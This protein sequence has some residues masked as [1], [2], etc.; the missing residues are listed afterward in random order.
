MPPVPTVEKRVKDC[1][2][3]TPAAPKIRNSRATPYRVAV[4]VGLHL[5]LAAHIAHYWLSGK[6][7]SPLEPSEAMEFSKHSIVNAGLVFFAVTILATLVFGRF[8]CGWGCHIVALQDLCR[9]MLLRV[10]IRPRPLRSRALALVPLGAFLYMFIWPLAYRVW[11]TFFG[12]AFGSASVQLQTNDFWRT[13]PGLGVT[14]FTFAVCG[15]AIVYL[16]GSKG[17]CTYACPYG[18]IFGF[19][20][21]FAPGR[22]RVTDACEGCG[23]CTATCT[24]NV[25]VAREVREFGMV[26]DAGCMKCLDCVSVCPKDAL[27]FGFGKPGVMARP[28]VERLS[29]RRFLPG[30]EEILGGLIFLVAFFTFRGLYGLVPFLLSLGLAASLAGLYLVLVRLV[31]KEPASL[32]GLVLAS[33]SKLTRAGRVYVVALLAFLPLWAHSAF[34]R[35]ENWRVDRLLIALAPVR[36]LWFAPGRTSDDDTRKGFAALRL[37]A[38][39]ADRFALLP[40]PRTTYALAWCALADGDTKAFLDKSG[41]AAAQGLEQPELFLARAQIERAAEDLPGAETDYRRALALHSHSAAAFAGLAELLAL[42]G[43]NDEAL[44]VL[45]AALA[46][47]PD[48]PRLHHDIAVVYMLSGSTSKAHSELERALDLDSRFLEARTKLATLEFA[49]GRYASALG[50][51]QEAAKLEPERREAHAALIDLCT[52]LG[53]AQKLRRALDDALARFP[54]DQD[55]LAR[56]AALDQTGDH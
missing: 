26:V 38:E 37:H 15:F 27:Y 17:F 34:V 45:R 47:H 13:F 29:P 30:R 54:S 39:R 36:D 24:S 44:T 2:R 1:S 3:G 51:L 11:R 9:A 31:R 33:E 50:L 52:T 4:L 41:R 19:V 12:D 16:L 5:L 55:L 42:R 28:R 56:R 43:A 14:L 18:A 53:D 40:D 49:A 48:N 46:E 23:H 8:F 21:R 25:D 20:D 32:P 35:Y 10:G 22:I 6:T 7:L